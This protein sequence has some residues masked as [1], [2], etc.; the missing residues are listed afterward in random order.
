MQINQI[1][2]F[3]AQTI[4]DNPLPNG[5]SI[6]YLVSQFHY[7]G[8]DESSMTQ[9]IYKN[10]D[11]FDKFP[12]DYSNADQSIIA[13]LSNMNIDH[14]TKTETAT[15]FADQWTSAYH[16][17]IRIQLTDHTLYVTIFE[18]GQY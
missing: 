15:A 9:L 4:K 10:I 12:E 5:N 13:T 14:Y 18:S 16:D 2:Q 6:Y 3:I 1:A 17:Y 8:A 11:N 7:Q